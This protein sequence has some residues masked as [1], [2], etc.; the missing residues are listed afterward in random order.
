M[1]V[2]ANQPKSWEDA[3]RA[4]KTFAWVLLL[5]KLLKVLKENELNAWPPRERGK[6][7]LIQ[8]KTGRIEISPQPKNMHMAPTKWNNPL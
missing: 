4:K 2:R 6:D 5:E 7:S 8:I 3:M 1:A